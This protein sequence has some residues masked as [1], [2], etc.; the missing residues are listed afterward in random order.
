MSAAEPAPAGQPTLYEARL[1]RMPPRRVQGQDID[2]D[3]LVI[4]GGFA[5]LWAAHALLARG[6]DVVV[7]ESGRIGAGASG[8]NAG[9]VGPGYAERPERIVRRVGLAD[10]R[11]LWR[12]SAEGGEIVRRL[13]PQV[14]DAQAIGGRLTV[15]RTDHLEATRRRAAW[16]QEAFD[17]RVDVLRT[18]QVRASLR[19][20]L[21]FQGLYYPDAF[22]LDPLAL[23]HGLAA[24]VEAAGGRIFE[25]TEARSADLAGLR[26]HV[27]TTGGRIRAEHVVLAGGV[28]V[29][30]ILPEVS[31]SIMPVTTFIGVTE[32]L[33]TQLDEAI[34]FR[35]A[36][37][38]TRRAGNYFRRIDDRLLWGAGFAIGTV[39]P[40]DMGERLARDLGRVFPSLAGA[41]MDYAW[42]GTMAYAVHRMPQIGPL[43]PGVWIAGA[44]GGHG[45]NTAAIAGELVA[46][47]IGEGD[48][49][50]KLFAPFGVVPAGGAAGRVA[51][52]MTMAVQGW[53]ERMLEARSR[54]R[55]AR[56]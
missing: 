24:Q 33:G 13:L 15:R 9:F 7:V 19:S 29:G 43:L 25:G 41:R 1:G 39:S 11:E 27:T 26:K 36:V 53:R 16:L 44:I 2:C 47:G 31:R 35:G 50:W 14:P 56:M 28:S 38:D 5:G 54:E 4:G 45:L 17:V 34:G 40:G 32:P 22:H 48:D 10:A 52:R 46:A 8:R 37:A 30:A 18:R 6:H 21:Y 55:A 49:R 42:A 51:A 20:P 3:V 12:L 23:L